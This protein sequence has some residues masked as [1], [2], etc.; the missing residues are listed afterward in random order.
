MYD[1]GPSTEHLAGLVRGVRDDQ[2]AAPTPCPAYSVADLLDHVATLAVGFARAARRETTGTG[3]PPAPDGARLRDGWRDQ[4]PVLLGDLGAVWSEPG[5]YDGETEIAGFRAPAPVICSVAA[6]EL[7]VHGWDLARA[8]G[9]LPGADVSGLVA[10][11][12]F[13]DQLGPAGSP[14]RSGGGFGDPVPVAEDASV[15]DHLVGNSGRDP[16]WVA[17]P[18]S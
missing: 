1:L 6:H 5:A 18:A 16:G 2:L 17:A 12:P 9:Q 4:I 10:A 13:A 3:G 8:T 7:V 11:R 14:L 15:L